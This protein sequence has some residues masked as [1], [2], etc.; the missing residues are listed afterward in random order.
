MRA[1]ASGLPAHGLADRI[2]RAPLAVSGVGHLAVLLLLVIGPFAIGRRLHDAP[3]MP[4]TVDWVLDDPGAR[5]SAA[6]TQAAKGRRVTPPAHVPATPAP[7]K[8]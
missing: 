5:A 1:P 3:M 7:P 8:P 4:A 6:A 2:Y